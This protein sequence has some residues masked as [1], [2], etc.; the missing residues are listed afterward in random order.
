MEQYAV[1]AEYKNIAILERKGDKPAIWQGH[2]YFTD[3]FIYIAWKKDGKMGTYSFGNERMAKHFIDDVTSHNDQESFGLQDYRQ[4]Y[5]YLY[6]YQLVGDPPTYQF[7]EVSGQ[8]VVAV[9]DGQYR[10]GNI[11]ER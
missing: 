11:F 7:D 8:F 2:Q 10:H 1:V 4:I 3:G 6:G 5:E 9:N